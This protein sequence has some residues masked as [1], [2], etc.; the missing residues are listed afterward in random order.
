[1]GIEVDSNT[2]TARLPPDKMARV[3]V[4]VTE[5]LQKGCMTQL[6]AQSLAG[7]LDFC[8]QVV[9]LGR[10]QLRPLFAFVASFPADMRRSAHRRL[11][12]EPRADLI[13]WKDL[14]PQFNGVRFLVDENRPIVHVVT[15]ASNIGL[16]LFFFKSS[17][18]NA[19]WSDYAAH[20]LP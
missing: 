20:L 17:H 9:L 2:M 16:G 19:S 13:W 10:S 7:F 6:E 15:D 3:L 12:V 1:L 18:A 4:A 11:H 14:L 8:A 5:A